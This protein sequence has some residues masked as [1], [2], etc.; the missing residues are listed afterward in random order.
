MIFRGKADAGP[1]GRALTIFFAASFTLPCL[2]GSTGVGTFPESP[3][4]T[5]TS[6]RNYEGISEAGSCKLGDR[7]STTSRSLSHKDHQ[8]NVQKSIVVQ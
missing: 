4:E 2:N 8:I 3:E 5:E 7:R 1:R 6:P